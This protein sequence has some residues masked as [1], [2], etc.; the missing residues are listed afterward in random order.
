M[1][2]I[3]YYWKISISKVVLGVDFRRISHIGIPAKTPELQK[4]PVS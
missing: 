3:D 4:H 2:T 1:V